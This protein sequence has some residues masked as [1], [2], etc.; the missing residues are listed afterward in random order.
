MNYTDMNRYTYRYIQREREGEREREWQC[1]KAMSHRFF[2]VEMERATASH[3][4]RMAE[5]LNSSGRPIAAGQSFQGGK[6]DPGKSNVHG[7]ILFI[8]V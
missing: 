7:D 5:A 1:G 2:L 3:S 6:K 8:W 4:G